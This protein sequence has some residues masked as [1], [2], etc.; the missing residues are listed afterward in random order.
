MQA[1]VCIFW[2]I[3]TGI[4]KW[5]PLKL[6]TDD[7]NAVLATSAYNIGIILTASVTW[8]ITDPELAADRSQLRGAVHA[9][10]A[11]SLIRSINCL[12]YADRFRSVVAATEGA[13]QKTNAYG[14]HVLSI[15]VTSFSA[16]GRIAHALA[17]DLIAVTEQARAETAK[18]GHARVADIRVGPA[19]V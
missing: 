7:L 14:V 3:G 5:I 13:N 10:V 12:S 8:R 6:Q 4:S 11:A 1:A 19:A 16:D 9:Q 15:C 17:D 18:G 2:T